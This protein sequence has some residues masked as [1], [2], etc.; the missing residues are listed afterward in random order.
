MTAKR[1]AKVTIV[2]TDL[3]PS[4]DGRSYIRIQRTS[5]PPLELDHPP[6]VDDFTL[7]QLMGEVA[8]AAVAEAMKK[9]FQGQEINIAPLKNA[10]GN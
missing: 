2:L 3:E 9:H 7:A 5:E 10:K 4:G 6:G 1:Y 8:V